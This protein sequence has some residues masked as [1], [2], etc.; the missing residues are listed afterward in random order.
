MNENVRRLLRQIAELEDELT[1]VLHEQQERLH[2]RVEGSK[3]RFEENL[4]RIHKKMKTGVFRWLLESE[5]R[6]VVS[7]PFIYAMIVPF[8]L[9]DAFLFVYQTICF[10]LYRIPKVRRSDYIVVDRH[11]LAYLNVIEKLNCA[12]CGYADGL[13]AYT[14][15]ILSRTEAYWCPIKH[16]RRIVDPHRRQARF[17]DFGDGE[18]YETHLRAMRDEVGAA[19]DP[20]Q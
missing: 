3:V 4:R 17:A 7:A 1:D 19:E 2:Y 11:R 18:N 13:L 14:R 8:A 20:E 9:L 10:P 16:A 5:L 6:S 12:Y 15:Q